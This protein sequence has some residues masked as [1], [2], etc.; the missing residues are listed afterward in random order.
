MWAVKAIPLLLDA[1]AAYRL[2]RLVTADTLT[3]K[4]R[5]LIVLGAYDRAGRPLPDQAEDAPTAV[6]LV[7]LDDHPPKLAE[8]VTCR[9]CAGVWVSA[10]V[11]A[12]GTFLPGA[13]AH[14]S[15]ALAL[16]AAAALLAGL[17]ED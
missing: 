10:G 3:E 1:L 13:W 8:L 9:W 5:K 14:V 17:E 7:E 15:R 4:P 16:S 12:V 11:V 2:T 6:D